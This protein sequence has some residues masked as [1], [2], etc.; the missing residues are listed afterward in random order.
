LALGV[1]HLCGE[2]VKRQAEVAGETSNGEERR[3]GYPVALELADRVD[4]NATSDGE[5]TLS[6][7]LALA[8]CA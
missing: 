1:E 5:L 8:R 6:G 3:G 7:V 4:R 2:P